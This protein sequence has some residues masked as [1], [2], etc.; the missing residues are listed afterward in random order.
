MRADACPLLQAE[1]GATILGTC[2][3]DPATFSH[4][5]T[6]MIPL[7]GMQTYTATVSGKVDVGGDVQQVPL[8]W[9]F[10]TQAYSLYLPVISR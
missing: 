2:Q 1:G 6:P 9:S 5:F 4:T 3:Y 8:V 7:A 10:T